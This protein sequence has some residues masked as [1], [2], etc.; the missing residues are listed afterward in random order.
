MILARDDLDSLVAIARLPAFRARSS[1]VTGAAELNRAPTGTECQGHFERLHGGLLQRGA[2][3]V[4]SSMFG[5]LTRMA[6]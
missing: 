5:R 4:S 6:K 1:P 2:G 3:T